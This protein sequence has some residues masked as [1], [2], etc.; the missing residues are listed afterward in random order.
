MGFNPLRVINKVS[1]VLT[2]PEIKRQSTTEMAA[3]LQN[4]ADLHHLLFRR[5]YLFTDAKGL[6]LEGFPFLGQW[7]QSSLGS[8]NGGGSH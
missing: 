4:R 3:L 7:V 5:G 8:L 2:K 6:N 1:R